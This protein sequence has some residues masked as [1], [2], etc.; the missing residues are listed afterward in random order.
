MF[1][2]SSKVLFLWGCLPVK[3]SSCEVVFPLSHLHWRSSS[4]E[5]IFMWGPLPVM[6]SS[7][8]VIF[9]HLH[10]LISSSNFKIWYFPGWGIDCKANLSQSWSWNLAELGNIK[11]VPANF[12]LW[13]INDNYLGARF[14]MNTSINILW[15]PWPCWIWKLI[16]ILA[17]KMTDILRNS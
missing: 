3:S 15:K 4:L 1:L 16:I 10:W 13:G 7:C 17:S 11:G 14:G 12:S 2:S 6:S 5:V 8:K 9:L